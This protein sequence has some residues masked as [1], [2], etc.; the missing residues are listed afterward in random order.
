[1]TGCFEDEPTG[2]EKAMPAAITAG[3]NPSNKL[4]SGYF[5]N[6]KPE[7]VGFLGRKKSF[8]EKRTGEVIENKSSA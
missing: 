6:Q 8:F 5:A 7:K 1:L 2:R 3:Y 4:Y